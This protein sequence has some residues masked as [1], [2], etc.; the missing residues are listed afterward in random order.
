[1]DAHLYDL[2]Y[3]IHKAVES[4]VRP[5]AVCRPTVYALSSWN[6]AKCTLHITPVNMSKYTSYMYHLFLFHFYFL[7]LL[8][9]LEFHVGAYKDFYVS[10][11]QCIFVVL[12]MF[13][14]MYL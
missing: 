12:G 7:S 2:F 10:V 9:G 6:T 13:T 4:G 8:K 14:Y 3:N 1:M 5:P 11:V